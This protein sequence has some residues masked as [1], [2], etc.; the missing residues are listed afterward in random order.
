MQNT[1]LVVCKL[2]Q[3][4]LGMTEELQRLLDEYPVF[5]SDGKQKVYSFD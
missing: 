1:G 2:I 3:S 5:E 4:I